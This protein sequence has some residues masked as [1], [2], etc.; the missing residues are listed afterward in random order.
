MRAKTLPDSTSLTPELEVCRPPLAFYSGLGDQTHILMR[1]RQA[2]HGQLSAPPIWKF[3]SMKSNAGILI[4]PSLGLAV[5]CW[6]SV[7]IYGG[8]GLLWQRGL[9]WYHEMLQGNALCGAGVCLSVDVGEAFHPNGCPRI[10]LR[11]SWLHAAVL[12]PGY[13]CRALG[14]EQSGAQETWDPLHD[15][16]ALTTVFPAPSPL[17]GTQRRGPQESVV[18]KRQRESKSVKGSTCCG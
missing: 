8:P 7:S 3:L 15:G 11:L 9:S 13:T 17:T 14:V 6:P 10:A 18:I 16:V 1:V 12:C 5:L 2:A 4:Y